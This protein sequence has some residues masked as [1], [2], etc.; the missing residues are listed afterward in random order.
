[1]RLHRRRA[2]YGSTR[3]ASSDPAIYAFPRVATHRNIYR[4]RLP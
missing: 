1:M 2:D 4:I 3:F